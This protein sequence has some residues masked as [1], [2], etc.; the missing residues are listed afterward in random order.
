MANK[1][2]TVRFDCWIT[3]AVEPDY[4]TKQNKRLIDWVRAQQGVISFRAT[5]LVTGTS[6]TEKI[7]RYDGNIYLKLAALKAE[8]EA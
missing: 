1:P 6:V 8:V 3:D 7:S 2:A 5:N 4:S